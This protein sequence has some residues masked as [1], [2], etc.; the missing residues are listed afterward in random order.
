MPDPRVCR[1]CDRPVVASAADYEVFE[2][3][4]YV[5]FHYEFEHEGDPDVECLSG[6]CPT[7]GVALPSRLMRTDGVDL[8]QAG[9]TVVPAILVLESL[10]YLVEQHGDRFTAK[11]GSARFSAEDPLAVLGLVKLAEARRPWRA[12]EAEIDE[13]LSRFSL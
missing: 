4:H 11:A 8:V 6:G 5:C 10:G 1:R 9:D 7:S 13:A 2:Q 3:M 12:T